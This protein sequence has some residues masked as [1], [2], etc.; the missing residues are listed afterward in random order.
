[1][2]SHVVRI[3]ENNI[4]KKIFTDELDGRRRVGRP[5]V[6]QADC[7]DADSRV[8]SCPD[9]ESCC[10]GTNQLEKACRGGPDTVAG[11]SA[12]Y[13]DDGVLAN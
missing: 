7:V 12:H 1:M 11:C 6:R 4:A 3:E 13:D 5:N 8:L 2:G 9:L 10:N